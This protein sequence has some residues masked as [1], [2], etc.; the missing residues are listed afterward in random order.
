[1][2]RSTL[3]MGEGARGGGGGPPGALLGGG[4]ALTSISRRRC[5]WKGWRR[6]YT[7]LVMPNL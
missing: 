3:V 1:L 4:I 7:K 6:A 5:G 2:L